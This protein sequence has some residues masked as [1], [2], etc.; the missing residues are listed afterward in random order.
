M[1]KF[2]LRWVLHALGT[3][4]KAERVTLSHGILSVLQR[5]RSSDFQSVIT[6]DKSWFILHY[7]RDLIRAS[8]RDKVPERVSQKATQKSA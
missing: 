3:N 2:H 8:S 5:V 6:G 7:P 1:K 4:Q